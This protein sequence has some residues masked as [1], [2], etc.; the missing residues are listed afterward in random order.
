[1]IIGVPKEIKTEEWRV[2]LTPAGTKALMEK[3]HKILIE[4][5]AGT[6]SG[7]SDDEYSEVGASLQEDKKNIFNEAKMIVKEKEP[8]P[9]E[10]DL[11]REGQILFTYLHLA[12]NKNLTLFL[13]KGFLTS[14]QDERAKDRCWML[15]AG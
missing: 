9:S 7:F 5:G 12:A 11:F 3:G 15:D 1:M 6:A 8:L 2:A 14:S 4:K 13:L 10:F